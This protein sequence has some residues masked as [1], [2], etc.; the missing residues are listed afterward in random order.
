[1]KKLLGMLC[2]L[3]AAMGGLAQSQMV[4]VTANGVRSEYAIVDFGR[5]VPDFSGGDTTLTVYARNGAVLQ[6]GARMVSYTVV[7]PEE[8]EEEEVV[9][10]T[11]TSTAS[12]SWPK[13][14]GANTYQLVVYEDQ[15]R[16]DILMTLTFNRDG[17]LVNEDR[18]G[19]RTG[20]ES[21]QS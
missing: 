3:L 5:L 11:T 9:I 17:R 1:M 18:T 14:E 4:V 19:L 10:E 13:V 7:P 2:G 12:F 21:F 15:S 20:P 6:S 8:F 16:E